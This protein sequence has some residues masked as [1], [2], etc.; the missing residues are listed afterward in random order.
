MV[1]EAPSDDFVFAV[2]R[3]EKVKVGQPLGDRTDKI[4]ELLG[5]QAVTESIAQ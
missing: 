1:F 5:K 4:A 2:K 3:G